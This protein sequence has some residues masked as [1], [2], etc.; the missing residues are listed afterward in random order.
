MLLSLADALMIVL[1]E[2]SRVLNAFV[3]RNNLKLSHLGY[4]GFCVILTQKFYLKVWFIELTLKMTIYLLLFI[5]WLQHIFEEICKQLSAIISYSR[6][7]SYLI[8]ILLY[9]YVYI[10][11]IL[12]YLTFKYLWEFWNCLILIFH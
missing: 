1:Y 4:L 5:K 7:C 12:Q 8:T 9:I 3:L 11:I 10:L 2:T 6:N